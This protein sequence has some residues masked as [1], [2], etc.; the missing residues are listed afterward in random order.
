MATY[1]QQTVTQVHHW[2][3]RTF[4]F[5]CT[6]DRA[7]RFAAGEFIMIGLEIDGRAVLRAYSVT[8]APW[9]EELEFLSIKIPHGQLTSRLQ[10]IQ[11][12]DTVLIG[13]R[14]TG[15]LRNEALEPGRDLWMLA[16][17]TGLAP[18]MS[19]V[20]DL[21]TIERWQHLHVVHSVRDSADLA[22][23]AQL[24]SQFAGQDLHDMVC[25]RLIYHP[26]VTGQGQARI[27]DQL[28][29]GLLDLDTDQDR[30]MLCGN[31]EFNRELSQWCQSR[32]MVEGLMRKPGEFVLERAFVEK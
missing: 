27:G 32:S 11:P 16:T 24:E 13:D 30:V 5:R 22:Y 14:A 29:Q 31:L 19:L 28:T 25:D 9:E 8:S 1:T 17:G 10:H 6:R 2:S 26:V 21:D 20:Q 7:F 23:C 15:T 3:D 12:G 18:F 4:S